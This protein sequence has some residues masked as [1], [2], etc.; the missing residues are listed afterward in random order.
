MGNQPGLLDGS[1][2]ATMIVPVQLMRGRASM[3][4]RLKP[5]FAGTVAEAAM[6]GEVYGPQSCLRSVVIV[7]V[8]PYRVNCL[9]ATIPPWPAQLIVNHAN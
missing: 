9:G 5:I 6:L 3:S 7:F 8:R 1:M 4:L 2:L